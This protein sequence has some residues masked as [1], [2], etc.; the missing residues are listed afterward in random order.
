[1]PLV[2]KQCQRA[3]R[4]ITAGIAESNGSLPLD[5][6]LVT[7][8]LT[9]DNR[10]Y[11]LTARWGSAPFSFYLWY[12]QQTAWRVVGCSHQLLWEYRAVIL[13]S[14]LCFLFS[15][16]NSPLRVRM[17]AR[18]AKTQYGTT[19]LSSADNYVHYSDPPGRHRHHSCFVEAWRWKYNVEQNV[20]PWCLLSYTM[21]D[22]Y[23][24]VI[25]IIT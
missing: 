24:L 22:I 13:D 3:A 18:I 4:K 17:R 2:S 1:M 6:W 8:G 11:G 12:K 19:Q 5:L 10:I 21:A 9:I 15:V 14:T 16:V 25:I 20:M 23:Q 7:C